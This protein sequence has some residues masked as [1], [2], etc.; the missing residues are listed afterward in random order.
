MLSI[1]KQVRYTDK[2]LL[3]NILILLV[4]IIFP[5]CFIVNNK[6]HNNEKLD[7]CEKNIKPVNNIP[8]KS[9]GIDD[10][11]FTGDTIEFGYN[12]KFKQ[13]KYEKIHTYSGPVNPNTQLIGFFP[14]T[15]IG[16][17][18]LI[19]T[20]GTIIVF[21]IT[22]SMPMNYTKWFIQSIDISDFQPVK[23]S[24]MAGNSR[25]FLTGYNK[26]NDKIIIKSIKINA[27]GTLNEEYN[28]TVHHPIN[29]TSVTSITIKSAVAPTDTFVTIAGNYINNSE[30]I[31]FIYEVKYDGS[32]VYDVLNLN[33]TNDYQLFDDS[34]F[35]CYS[36]APG[37]IYYITTNE[38]VITWTRQTSTIYDKINLNIS[39][40]LLLHVDF[41]D[42]H[43]TGG[44]I[45]NDWFGFS[46]LESIST[47]KPE[48]Y[49]VEIDISY[50]LFVTKTDKLFAWL[51]ETIA[52][53]NIFGSMPDSSDSNLVFGADKNLR[54]WQE[55]ISTTGDQ[56]GAFNWYYP[57]SFI[58]SS[59]DNKFE[60]GFADT[61]GFWVSQF[62]SNLDE[63][64]NISTTKITSIYNNR[65]SIEHLKG[66]S[67]FT[68]RISGVIE[69]NDTNVV[70]IGV[71]PLLIDSGSELFFTV[72]S[73]YNV[74]NEILITPI[75]NFFG[76]GSKNIEFNVAFESE[77]APIIDTLSGIEY[78]DL[79]VDYVIYEKYSNGTYTQAYYSS[80]NDEV[81]SFLFFFDYDMETQVVLVDSH[82]LEE[83][84]IEVDG[85]EY[86]P[87]GI[88]FFKPWGNVT[89]RDKITNDTLFEGTY[90]FFSDPLNIP[91]PSKYEFWISYYSNLD[92]FGFDF[93][94]VNT[95]INETEITT[96]SVRIL[97]PNAEIVVKD[98]SDD[99]LYNK[100]FSKNEDGEYI[101]IGLDVAQIIISNQYNFTIWFYLRKNE[102]SI[103]YQLPP[104]TSIVLRLAL[105]TYRYLVT[106]VDGNEIIDDEIEFD[107]A[108]TLVIGEFS[109]EIGTIPV[110]GI[111]TLDLVVATL[112][113]IGMAVFLALMG[114]FVRPSKGKRN[115]VTEKKGY[116]KPKIKKPKKGKGNVILPFS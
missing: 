32:T 27:D 9:T 37:S 3:I 36:S 102:K 108:E 71:M 104:T 77:F 63:F 53:D 51:I 4:I 114:Y 87:Y 74:T 115:S 10:I 46:T 41:S 68:I 83:L 99:I 13:F 42:F 91:I 59:G 7:I 72:D 92:Y 26:T 95:F 15:A 107:A 22:D 93:N 88:K 90:T 69:R 1:K 25:L 109:F 58:K 39:L 94:L 96:E 18:L 98:F 45:I 30:S 112:I 75:Q 103:A 44:G 86:E 81:K 116:S 16:H 106:D 8:V 38:Q 110:V 35:Y 64:Y 97:S 29:L 23:A 19:F 47:F 54:I 113:V 70:E 14:L 48:F 24:S 82:L 6:I 11:N 79:L 50:N 12:S 100:T 80:N 56:A 76:I 89:I 61:R 5:T 62:S 34:V 73:V 52:P 31:P 17:R 101:K 55:F 105:G 65:V 66:T 111:T 40:N 49:L 20:N 21:N 57:V 43:V 2:N 85:I 33:S 78:V 84:H 67:K 28:V 60:I